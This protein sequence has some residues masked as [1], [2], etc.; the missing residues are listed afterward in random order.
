MKGDSRRGSSARSEHAGISKVRLDAV[1]P[2]DEARIDALLGRLEAY[3]TRVD[4]VARVDDGARTFLEERP[5]GIPARQKHT[6]VVV[7]DGEDAGL[8]DIVDGF[9]RAGTAFVGLL[10]V[11]EDRH[12]Q[13]IGRAAWQALEAFA[14]NTLAAEV[15]RLA[16]VDANPVE[17]FWQRQGFERTGES[18]PYTGLARQSTAWLM[19][20][21]V[22][23]PDRA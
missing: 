16:V 4:G 23:P 18:S 7:A 6:F 1:G 5:P 9:P 21:R 19:E 14:R 8:A 17:G 12:G 3:S 15:L 20:K 13:G 11:R 2:G 22:R 10:A